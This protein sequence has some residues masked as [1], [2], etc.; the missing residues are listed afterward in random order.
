L[1]RS[2]HIDCFH[3][4]GDTAQTRDSALR[5]LQEL[6]RHDCR[7]KVWVD[8]A[9]APT[10]LGADIMSGRGDI[11]GDA[12]Y[13][14][15]LTV[16]HGVRYVWLGRVTA[17][18]GQDVGYSPLTS[19]HGAAG[20][21]PVLN[22]VKDSAKFVR[23]S[24]GDRKYGMH[25]G[26]R[27]TRSHTL[28]DGQRLVEF[29]RCNPNPLG[30]SVGDNS[31]G[32]ASALRP[33]VLDQLVTRGGFS[34]LYTHLGKGL[35]HRTMIPEASRLAFESLADYQRRGQILVTTTRRLLDYHQMTRSIEF[36]VDSGSINIT[37]NG[38]CLD[39]LTMEGLD[40][41]ME[42]LVDGERVFPEKHDSGSRRTS[43]H[44]L[45]WPRLR[46]PL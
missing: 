8:H 1:I 26:N 45:P 21:G 4:F 9:V 6:E 20:M 24:L 28:R 31:P 35:D 34:I 16:A 33:A 25:A 22:A 37:S 7:L 3:S 18:M 2:G 15:D 14:L 5:S 39:G 13:H 32:I 42:C 19:L 43:V 12:A 27:L 30:V 29:M 40:E 11:P 17:C 44:S 41:G 36:H 23:G 10:N 46:W 38:A